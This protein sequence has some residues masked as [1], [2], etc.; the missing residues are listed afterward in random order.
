LKYLFVLTG[1]GFIFAGITMYI[2][3][4]Q[5]VAVGDAIVNALEIITIIIPPT[6]P[7]ALGAGISLA[8]NRLEG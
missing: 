7:T 1:L 6:L 2:S 5:N 3:Y 4:L 8:I